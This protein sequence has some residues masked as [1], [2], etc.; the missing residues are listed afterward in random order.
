M[1]NNM[2]G[3]QKIEL[4]CDPTIPFLGIYPKEY[5]SGYNKLTFT[6][7]FIG[8]LFTIANL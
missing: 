2:E 5:K 1:E 7:M 3:P 6:P 4:P 8:A